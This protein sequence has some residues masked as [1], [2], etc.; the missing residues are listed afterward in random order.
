[1]D[2]T[3]LATLRWH[4]DRVGLAAEALERALSEACREIARVLRRAGL[5]Q[6][7]L[8]APVPYVGP[9]GD[10]HGQLE[11][12]RT[13]AHGGLVFVDD[14]RETVDAQSVDADVLRVALSR[15]DLRVALAALAGEEAR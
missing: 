5:E 15:I 10:Y 8:T 14:C 4:A 13:D 3:L 12:I 9:E 1:M 2:E 11:A 7:T 6:V